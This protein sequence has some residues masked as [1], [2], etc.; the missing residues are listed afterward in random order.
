MHLFNDINIRTSE[1]RYIFYLLHYYFLVFE[2]DAKD[3]YT[4]CVATA[5]VNLQF[6]LNNHYNY[7]NSLL[8]T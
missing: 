4:G 8:Y 3:G 7:G 5:T 2:K 1:Y 6:T